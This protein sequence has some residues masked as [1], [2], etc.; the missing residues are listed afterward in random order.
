M[1]VFKICMCVYI[2]VRVRRGMCER[3]AIKLAVEYLLWKEGMA[4]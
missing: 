2:G 3:K 4:W 1:C